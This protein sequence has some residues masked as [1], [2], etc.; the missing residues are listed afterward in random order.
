MQNDET[1]TRRAGERFDRRRAGRLIK[2]RSAE[3]D[4][5][6]E[7]PVPDGAAVSAEG[8]GQAGRDDVCHILG[9]GGGKH[10]KG[11]KV[12]DVVIHSKYLS[13]FDDSIITYFVEFVKCFFNFF[14]G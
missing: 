10:L 2:T 6:R 3:A 12:D 5:F 1:Q 7:I 9:G 11:G 4:L 8:F 13:F 14:E